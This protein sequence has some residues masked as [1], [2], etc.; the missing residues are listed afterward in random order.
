PVPPNSTPTNRSGT[1]EV[2][3]A[4]V[5]VTSCQAFFVASG[6]VA[7]IVVSVQSMT[8]A[9]TPPTLSVPGVVPKRVPVT[10]IVSPR[11]AIVGDTVLACGAS[12]PLGPPQAASK[13]TLQIV[14]SLSNCRIELLPGREWSDCNGQE[15]VCPM[16]YRNSPLYR[17]RCR[18]VH[19]LHGFD[20]PR[21]QPPRQRSRT[22][23][24]ANGTSFSTR[25]RRSSSM[26]MRLGVQPSAGSFARRASTS[27]ACLKRSARST[28]SAPPA[29]SGANR[30]KPRMK[31]GTK[32]SIAASAGLSRCDLTA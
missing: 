26:A 17:R 2:P 31:G 9:S 5:T 11:A 19:N 7:S 24:A 8:A 12:G 29:G 27:S 4:V 18:A 21:G 1:E 3:P 28:A 22:P 16:T 23:G 14:A 30:R 20:A 15:T 13:T 6:T 25:A 32:D 10:V